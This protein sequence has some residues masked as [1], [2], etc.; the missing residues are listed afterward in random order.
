VATKTGVTL[1]DEALF[2]LYILDNIDWINRS[3]S[4]SYG[5]FK[6]ERGN[7]YGSK[8]VQAGVDFSFEVMNFRRIECE[9][10]ANNLPSVRCVEKA[11]FVQEG[12]KRK[13][14]YRCGN[15]INSVVYGILDSDWIALPRVKEM[16][17]LCNTNYSTK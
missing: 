11:G 7:G 5:V 17:Y 12:V 8:L 13:A 6:A 10:L 16:N 15:D 4:M 3:Y 9:V 14:V 1:K 2:G